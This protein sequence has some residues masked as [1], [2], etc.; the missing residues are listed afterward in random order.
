MLRELLEV[1]DG[2]LR[3]LDA[4][5]ID[6]ARAALWALAETLRSHVTPRTNMAF[7]RS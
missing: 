2:A 6:A 3:A 7:E 1:V 4:G 5:E